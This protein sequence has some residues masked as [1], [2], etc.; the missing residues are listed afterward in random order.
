MEGARR[1]LLTL[2]GVAALLWLPASIAV[3]TIRPG[4]GLG[5]IISGIFAGFIGVALVGL[6]SGERHP[7]PGP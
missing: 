1:L 4:Y 3:Y 6:A 5:I 2:A 7:N